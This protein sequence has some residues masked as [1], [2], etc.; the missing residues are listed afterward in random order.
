MYLAD[1]RTLAAQTDVAHAQDSYAYDPTVGVTSGIYW[2]GGVLPWAMPLNQ[3]GDEIKSLTFTTAPFERDIEL[4]GEPRAVL[5][6]SST[7][8]S[9]YFHVKISDVAPDGTSKWLTDGGL[10]TSHRTSHTNPEP[11]GAGQ[12][13]ELQIR[14]KFV[15]YML[16]GGHSLRFSVASA[17]LQ[18]AWH[19]ASPA[20]HTLHRGAEFPSRVVL[21]LAP[22][23]AP[24]LPPPALKPSPP[25]RADRKRFWRLVAQDHAR[26]RERHGHGRAGAHQRIHAEQQRCATCLWRESRQPRGALALYRLAQ[27]PGADVPERQAH[28]YD[29]T[30]GG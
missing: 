3:R 2:G 23:D 28:L 8:E 27:G 11:M 6:V 16:P 26:S 25:L 18:H 30:S 13:C 12:V 17:D 1:G 19:C 7:A 21:P 10:L 20:V 22:V 4:T 15:A 5:Y 29:Y 14:L 9:G 24:K